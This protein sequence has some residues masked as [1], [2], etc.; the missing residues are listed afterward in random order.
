MSEINCCGGTMNGNMKKNIKHGAS[1]AFDWEK[2]S[3]QCE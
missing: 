2:M 1:F 3:Q